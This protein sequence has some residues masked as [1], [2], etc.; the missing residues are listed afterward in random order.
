MIKE[1]LLII[2]MGTT[3][4]FTLQGVYW[5]WKTCDQARSELIKT[6]DQNFTVA[7]VQDFREGRS[8]Y[9]R[10]TVTEGIAK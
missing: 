6:L 9:P 4:N 1:W 8:R 5:D 7:C 2:W 10:S 3:T